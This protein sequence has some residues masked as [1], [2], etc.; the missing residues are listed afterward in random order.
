MK[1]VRNRLRFLLENGPNY[2]GL[3]WWYVEERNDQ[4]AYDQAVEAA[5]S[6]WINAVAAIL[7]ISQEENLLQIWRKVTL[8]QGNEDEYKIV[9]A[10]IIERIGNS[11]LPKPHEDM[12]DDIKEDYE[13]ARDVFP[14]SARSSAAL[15][16][17]ALQKL[18]EVLGG[19]GK[20]INT[21]IGIL[22]S[23]GLPEHIQQALDV[24]RVIGNEAVHPGV[25]NVRDNPEIAMELFT[26]LN[27]IVEN[28]ISMKKRIKDRY[29]S[30]PPNK[31]QGIQDRAKK[32]SK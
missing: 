21:D 25:I 6:Q 27:E 12:P 31:L 2:S 13:E 14:Y 16:R 30:L 15:S 24:V 19:E 10:Q 28:Q 18:C 11:S 29:N 3:Y 1:T 22:V 9:L 8:T 5:R 32:Y 20:E 17:L 23:K 7:E 26:L 4:A